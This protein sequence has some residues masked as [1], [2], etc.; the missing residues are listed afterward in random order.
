M[1]VNKQEFKERL[2][3]KR[4]VYTPLLINNFWEDLESVGWV[5]FDES[6]LKRRLDDLETSIRYDPRV[7]ASIDLVK[8]LRKEI[9]GGEGE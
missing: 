6:A 1:K 2:S 9:W 5:L 7:D 4:A 8:R 3:K